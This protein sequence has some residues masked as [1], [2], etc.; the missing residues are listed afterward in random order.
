MPPIVILVPRGG[1]FYGRP[2]TSFPEMNS[3]SYMSL[4][5]LMGQM[6]SRAGIDARG[7]DDKCALARMGYFHGYKGYRFSGSPARRIPYMPA[8]M[9][10]WPWW[11]STA[12]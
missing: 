7:S 2:Q 12:A 10:S 1:S 9:S 4:D 6:Q 3:H 11:T 8:S 5:A